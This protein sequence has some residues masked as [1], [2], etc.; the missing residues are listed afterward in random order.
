MIDED[1]TE[2]ERVFGEAQ[3]IYCAQHLRPHLTGWCSVPVSQK[4][5]LGVSTEKEAYA[6]CALLGLSVFKG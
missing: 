4:L 1:M 2:D 5:G 6:K 3:W